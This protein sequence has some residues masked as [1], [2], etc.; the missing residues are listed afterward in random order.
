MRKQDK[1]YLKLVKPIYPRF[2][3]ITFISI[4]Y[5][6]AILLLPFLIGF[7]VKNNNGTLFFAIFPQFITLFAFIITLI[8]SI[9]KTKS[10]F[11]CDISQENNGLAYIAIV[12]ISFSI[13]FSNSDLIS[14]SQFCYYFWLIT[15]IYFLLVALANTYIV[16]SDGFNNIPKQYIVNLF[17]DFSIAIILIII[18]ANMNVVS[19]LGID[20][21]LFYKGQPLYLYLMS[22]DVLIDLSPGDTIALFLVPFLIITI[23]LGEMCSISHKLRTSYIASEVTAKAYANDNLTKNNKTQ[24]GNDKLLN[25][26]REVSFYVKCE[27]SILNWIIIFI[28]GVVLLLSK[29]DFIRNISSEIGELCN[30]IDVFSLS[31]ILPVIILAIVAFVFNV[32]TDKKNSQKEDELLDT[33]EALEATETENVED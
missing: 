33:I 19:F 20:Y 7:Y 21:S 15:M 1:G 3:L 26:Y 6:V 16:L 10:I 29:A 18:S 31:F 32:T 12:Y 9:E 13:F 8:I 5:V 30:M 14:I 28:I 22:H 23:S 11:A 27:T 24:A 4:T 17:I 2:A 25:M